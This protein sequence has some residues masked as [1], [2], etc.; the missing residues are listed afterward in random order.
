[1][2]AGVLLVD[3][4]TGFRRMARRLLVAAGFDVVGEAADG[5]EGIRRAEA[6]HPS[7]VVL[8]VLLPDLDGFA[9]AARLAG[10]PDPPAVVLI[11]ARSRADLGDRLDTAPVRG[12]L[13]KDRLTARTLAELL[14]PP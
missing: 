11:S 8:D 13:P 1:M 12:F 14:G 4:H 3:D 10:L 9:V 7:I 2:A 5:A 6:L